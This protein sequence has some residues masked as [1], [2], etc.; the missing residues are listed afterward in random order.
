VTTIGEAPRLQLTV[1]Q[2]DVLHLLCRGAADRQIAAH[3]HASVRTVQREISRIRA[4]LG[5]PSRT[6][7]IASAM[8]ADVVG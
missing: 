7:L 4:A 6:T 3:I 1:R 5:A 8:R 2:R